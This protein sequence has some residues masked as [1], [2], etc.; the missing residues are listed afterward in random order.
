MTLNEIQPKVD[1]PEKL[2]AVANLPVNQVLFAPEFNAILDN[3]KTMIN[4]APLE[5]VDSVPSIVVTGNIDTLV[6]EYD[7]GKLINRKGLFFA[8]LVHKTVLAAETLNIGIAIFD[9]DANVSYPLCFGS[10]NGFTV[11][12]GVRRS[13]AIDGNKLRVAQPGNAF[14]DDVN[15]INDNIVEHTIDPNH[16]FKLQVR[17]FNSWINCGIRT[18]LVNVKLK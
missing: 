17:L 14:T 18:Y 12:I 13:V 7:L 10:S 3:L 6:K 15:Y 16:N 8:A 2:A 5:I 1:S 4:N 11:Q 9:V